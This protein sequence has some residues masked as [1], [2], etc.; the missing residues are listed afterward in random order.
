M[1]FIYF[2]A[3]MALS[4]ASFAQTYSK[5]ISRTLSI[6]EISKS[7]FH[8][9][10]KDNRFRNTIDPSIPFVQLHEIIRDDGAVFHILIQED[11]VG[12]PVA[13]G[14]DREL[15]KVF[16]CENKNTYSFNECIRKKEADSWT[17]Q[18]FV[19]YMDCIVERLNRCT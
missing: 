5:G 14:I 2:L 8:F 11:I 1:K 7:A 10:E 12:K 9:L 19:A 3:V 6:K 4:V 17:I 16:Q 15:M 18:Q 13:L